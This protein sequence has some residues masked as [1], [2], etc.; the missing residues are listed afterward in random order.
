MKVDNA[1]P[2]LSVPKIFEWSIGPGAAAEDSNYTVQMKRQTTSG[3]WTAVTPSP[4]DPASSACKANAGR[5]STAA[6]SAG[7]VLGTWGFNQRGGFR[8]VCVPGAEF[9]LSRADANGII[10]EYAVVAG[11]AVNYATMLFQE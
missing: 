5:V 4:L 8:Y 11:T 1:T 10:L 7:V 2:M 3:T 6:G 9:V